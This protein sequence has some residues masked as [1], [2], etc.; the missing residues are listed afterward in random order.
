MF[1]AD[2]RIVNFP[3]QFCLGNICNEFGALQSRQ[4]SLK[5]NMHDA[6]VNYNAIDESDILKS[7][8]RNS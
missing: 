6:S 3:T 4:L 7:Q 1:K 2:N 8:I 5:G